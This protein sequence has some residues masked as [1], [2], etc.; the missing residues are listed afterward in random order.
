M[1]YCQ[2]L[3][4]LADR[5]YR[6]NSEL[7]IMKPM[8]SKHSTATPGLA[9]IA[10]QLMLNCSHSECGVYAP[11][12]VHLCKSSC[13]IGRDVMQVMRSISARRHR[14]RLAHPPPGHGNA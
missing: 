14:L 11:Q 5:Y 4:S 6:S 12:S 2:A 3:S 7:R 9:A 13:S 1:T 10:L 8:H